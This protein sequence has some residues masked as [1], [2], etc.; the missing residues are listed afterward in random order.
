MD[1]EQLQ[2]IL[3]TAREVSQGAWRIALIW[4]ARPYFAIAAWGGVVI[5]VARLFFQTLKGRF[6]SNE[7]DWA[8]TEGDW[9]HPTT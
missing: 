7:S 1:I 6:V 4:V 5:I 2:L 3:D 8:L 9:D